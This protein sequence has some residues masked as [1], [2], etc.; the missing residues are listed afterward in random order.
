MVWGLLFFSNKA[1][2]LLLKQE[3]GLEEFDK[4]EALT[5][6]Q[7]DSNHAYAPPKR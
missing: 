6:L 5:S 1:A 3:T 7:P 4:A 2:I